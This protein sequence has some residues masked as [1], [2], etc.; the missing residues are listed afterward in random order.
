[1][2]T[3][4][5]YE[6]NDLSAEKRLKVIERLTNEEIDFQLSILN[7]DLN[8]LRIT[9]KEYYAELNCSKN[10][11]ES[12]AWFVPSCYYHKHKIDIDIAVQELV[13]TL[14]FDKYGNTIAI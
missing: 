11:A 9:E 4:N 3:I 7:N 10:Y 6:F 8:M 14:I 13:E 12:T 2:K 5:A 1:M